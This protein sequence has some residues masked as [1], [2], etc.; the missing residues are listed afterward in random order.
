MKKLF[1]ILLACLM[2]TGLMAKSKMTFVVAGEEESYNMI[3]VVNETAMDDITCR[4]VIVEDDDSVA[5]VY[6]IYKLKGR[7]DSDA[8]AKRV[9]RGT[10]LGVQMPNDF[11]KEVS[12]SVE[13]KDYPVWDMIII[14][15]R[16]AEG[17]F[18]DKVK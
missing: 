14:Y 2:T 5:A 12:F 10:R 6:G 9:W 11:K 4:I 18:A 7:Y 15:L 8:C 17:S 16:D 3:K 1:F 13:Y